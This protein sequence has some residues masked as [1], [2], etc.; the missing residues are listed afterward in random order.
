MFLQSIITLLVN[1]LDWLYTAI[2]SDVV[3][4]FCNG[5]HYLSFDLRRE[6]KHFSAMKFRSVS[7]QVMDFDIVQ[8]SK[9]LEA[10]RKK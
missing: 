4:L 5:D 10:E 7:L 3:Q 2:R 8:A 9:R 6:S 1:V